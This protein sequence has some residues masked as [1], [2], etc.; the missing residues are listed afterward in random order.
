MKTRYLKPQ[1]FLLSGLLLT[2]AS[3]ENLVE[4]DF[5]SNQI[6]TQ[7]VFQD[8]QTAN[9]ALAGLY[10]GLWED[11]PVS[12][13]ARGAGAL[14]GIYADD[15]ESH[16]TSVVNAEYD[17]YRN[18]QIDDNVAVYAYWTSAYQKVYQANAI[19]GGMAGSSGISGSEKQRIKGEALFIRSLVLFYLQQAFGNIPYPTTTDYEIN[20]NLSK[21]NAAATLQKL[22][23]D[24]KEAV[25]LLSD[26]YR[27]P[28]RIVVNRKAAE[29]LLAKVLMS[30]NKWNEAEVLL[31]GIVTNPLYQFEPD[32]SKVF[33]KNGKHILFQLKPKNAV[34]PTKEATLYYFVNS[35]PSVYSLSS[36]L[37]SSFT[38]GDLRKSQWI[39]PVSFN[40]ATKYRPSKYKAISNNSTEYSIVFR[41]EEVYLLLAEALAQQNKLTEALSFVNA[42][43]ERAGLPALS[44]TVTKE[45]LKT[46]ILAENRKEFFAE[47]GLR[48]MNLKRAGMLGML[49]LTKPNF[50]TYHA[51]WPIPQKELLLNKNLNPQNE[52]Y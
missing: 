26:S 5:P 14:L 24:L 38:S 50:K 40:Q 15:L 37:V 33:L 51:F 10:A 30:Q 6:S 22:E 32:L 3:C 8:V 19:I 25:P 52:G 28:E 9:A 31:K 36:D 11:S 20:R 41:L 35:A 16:A 17:L 27:E 45:S 46:E 34:D 43:R 18:I 49:S 1:L 13:G 47:M 42:T 39:T 12:G 44:S 21:I 23:D 7:L 4:V 29:F 2:M 48:F